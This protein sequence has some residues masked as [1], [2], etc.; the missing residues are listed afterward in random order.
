MFARHI[1][2]LLPLYGRSTGTGKP[3]MLFFNRG[4]EP[5]Q[6]DPIADR[7]SNAHMLILG[8]TG[9]GKSALLVYDLLMVMAVHRPRVFIIEA[10][11]SFSLLGQYFASLGLAVN[12]V[13]LRPGVDVSLPPFADALKLAGI[14]PQSKGQD[15]GTTQTQSQT[16]SDAM[17]IDRVVS[18]VE[19]NADETPGREG[20]IEAG[21]DLLGEMEISARLM[22]TGGD[23]HEDARLTRADRWLI[24]QAILVAVGQVKNSGRGQVLTEDVASALRAMAAERP[25]GLRTWPTPWGISAHRALAAHFFNRPGKLWPDADVTI[26]EMGVRLGM[27][28]RTSWR[29]PTSA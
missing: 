20:T 9:S 26:F 12:Q 10:G 18:G 21:R 25:N 16:Q 5:V 1:A 2:N 17:E 4:G 14:L 29:W 27:A 6:F 3:G 7:K 11:G 8:P 19:E 24:Q 22:I 13:T 23:A 28:T 15:Q